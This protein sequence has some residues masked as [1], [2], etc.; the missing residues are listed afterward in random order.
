MGGHWEK[1][2]VGVRQ[3]ARILALKTERGEESLAGAMCRQSISITGTAL[4]LGDQ[5]RPV[6][7]TI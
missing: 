2:I 1:R 5:P 4:G 7:D 6:L 3:L